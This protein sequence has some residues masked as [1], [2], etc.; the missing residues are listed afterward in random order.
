MIAYEEPCRRPSSTAKSALVGL[1]ADRRRVA[2]LTEGEARAARGYKANKLGYDRGL[3]DL[4]TA[5]SAEQSWR[6]TRSQLTAAQVQAA[7]R[8]IQVYKALGGGW[9]AEHWL[10]Q[11][12][13][14]GPA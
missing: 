7:R 1:D 4:Q 5:L 14:G 12:G 6:T 11:A 3:T 8:T 9:P 10:R 13:R 2:L